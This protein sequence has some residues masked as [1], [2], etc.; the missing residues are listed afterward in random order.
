LYFNIRRGRK[1]EIQDPTPCRVVVPVHRRVPFSPR[2]AASRWSFA[3]CKS[4]RSRTSYGLSVRVGDAEA[5]IYRKPV[6]LGVRSCIS[7]SD[8]AEMLKYKI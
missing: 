2:L 8:G 3:G 6:S 7:T 5:C 1:V 4:G